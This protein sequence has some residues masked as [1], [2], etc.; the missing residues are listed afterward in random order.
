MGS[1]RSALG[2]AAAA[3][4]WAALEPIDMLLLRNDYC[5]V[6]LLGKAVTRSRW[7]PVAG[8]AIH[9]ANGAAFGLVFDELRRRAAIPPRRLAIGL[10]LAE[11]TLLFPI[12]H[13]VDRVH[14]ERCDRGVA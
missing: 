12:G 1:L 8:L 9:A 14:L 3:T 10:A 7:W 6:A 13:V 4:V 2:G 5:D 11:H